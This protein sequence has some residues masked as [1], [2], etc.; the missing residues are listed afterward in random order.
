MVLDNAVYAFPF[1][2]EST[3]LLKPFLGDPDDIE[4]LKVLKVLELYSQGQDSA[5]EFIAKSVDW[6]GL[7]SVRGLQDLFYFF[8]KC[9]ASLNMTS[10]C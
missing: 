5:Q 10:P 1:D 8:K 2:L 3:L 6:Q 9:H 7:M 4:L